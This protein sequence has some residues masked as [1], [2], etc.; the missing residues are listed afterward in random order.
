MRRPMAIVL[1]LVVI[2]AIILLIAFLGS[3]TSQQIIR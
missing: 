3:N 2:I 1:V